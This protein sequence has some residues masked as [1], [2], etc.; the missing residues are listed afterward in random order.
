MDWETLALARAHGIQ[1]VAFS[2]L[3]E[4]F[5]DHPTL[6]P[7]VDAIAASHGVSRYQAMMAY[8][9]MR[10]VTVLSSCFSA[11]ARC[12]AHYADDLAM[13]RVTLTSAEMSAL[14]ALTLGKRTCT[15]C[16]TDE[17]QARAPPPA[18]TPATTPAPSPAA[19]TPL[20]HLITSHLLTVTVTRNHPHPI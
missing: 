5:T 18:T 15:D 4:A 17:C 11:P 16:F 19:C 20:P 14:D 10:N 7:V 1:P 9:R 6:T 12:A 3:S 8:V 13:L 2:T